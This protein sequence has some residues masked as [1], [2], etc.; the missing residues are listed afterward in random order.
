MLNCTWRLLD[1]QPTAQEVNGRLLAYAY[2]GFYGWKG[3]RIGRAK[4]AEV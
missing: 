3:H 1:T 2:V 4:S